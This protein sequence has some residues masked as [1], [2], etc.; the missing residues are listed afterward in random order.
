MLLFFLQLIV[1][2]GASRAQRLPVCRDRSLSHRIPSRRRTQRSL[3][4]G[5]MLRKPPANGRAAEP[6][7]T[8]SS[9]N[10]RFYIRCPQS[11]RWV[12]LHRSEY[13]FRNIIYIVGLDRLIAYKKL[14][15]KNYK[16]NLLLL[17]I[18]EVYVLTKMVRTFI[19]HF[20]QHFVMLLKWNGSNKMSQNLW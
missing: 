11:M 9:Y 15:T 8:I 5:A 6:M 13:I 1:I 17:M 19:R 14:N 3:R 2:A 12:H 20:N 4:L 10:M 18:W 16:L 7:V